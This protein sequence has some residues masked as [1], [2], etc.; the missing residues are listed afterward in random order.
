MLSFLPWKNYCG[1]GIVTALIQ[2]SRIPPSMF[3][4]G[5][6]LL[7]GPMV[8]L[9]VLQHF[10]KIVLPWLVLSRGNIGQD[11]ALKRHSFDF[12]GCL[13]AAL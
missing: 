2:C 3:F 10:V 7:S 11:L 9:G 12:S 4:S 8:L 1:T 5:Y 13:Q 6:G